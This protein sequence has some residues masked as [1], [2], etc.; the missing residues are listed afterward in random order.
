MTYRT[1]SGWN[2]R[3]ELRCLLIFK[4][5]IEED[6]PHGKQSEYCREM[7][8]ITGLDE[9]SISARVSNYKSVAG[10]NDGSNASSNTIEIYQKYNHLTVEELR[11]LIDDLE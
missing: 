5:L 8:D 1:G 6:F 11:K 7:A 10:I 4:M 3:N 9:N 2:D